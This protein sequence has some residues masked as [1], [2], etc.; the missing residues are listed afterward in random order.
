MQPPTPSYYSLKP[1]IDKARETNWLLKQEE[2]KKY[3]SEFVFWGEFFGFV[4]DFISNV[5][6][7]TVVNN[8]ISWGSQMKFGG[9][10]E[11]ISL[12]FM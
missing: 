5:G 3:Y 9:L 10:E 6:L 12:H 2:K 4:S 7:F 1:G 11:D 8:S